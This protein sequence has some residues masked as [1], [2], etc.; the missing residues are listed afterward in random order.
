MT[1]VCI[2]LE[3]AV[4]GEGGGVVVAVATAVVA[5]EAVAMV[6]RRAR[7]MRFEGQS[8]PGGQPTM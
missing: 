4:E 5:T 8:E 1:M 6:L 2:G 7:A 3:A